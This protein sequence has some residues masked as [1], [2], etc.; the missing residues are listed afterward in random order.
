MVISDYIAIQII[1][2][3]QFITMLIIGFLLLVLLRKKI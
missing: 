3:K 1:T 2:P